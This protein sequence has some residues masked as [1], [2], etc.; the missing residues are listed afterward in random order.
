MLDGDTAWGA[1]TIHPQ[2]WG[3]TSYR[4]VM[5]PPGIS[6]EERRRVRLW[7]GLPGWG[8]AMWL[9]ATAILSGFTDPWSA[10]ITASVATAAAALVTYARAK[11]AR[12]LVRSAQVTVGAPNSDTAMLVRARL[13]ETVGT[14]M[15]RADRR[16]ADGEISPTDHEALWWRAYDQL[17]KNTVIPSIGRYGSVR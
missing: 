8:T 3:A 16:L 12:T 6:V 11:T 1:M 14:A 9:S 4:I 7:R 15:T 13:I 10:L 17:D 2:R 5:Y